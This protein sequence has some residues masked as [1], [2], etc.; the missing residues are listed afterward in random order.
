MSYLKDSRELVRRLGSGEEQHR[1][2]GQIA[3]GHCENISCDLIE[4]VRRILQSRDCPTHRFR[5]KVSTLCAEW[6]SA[7]LHGRDD[8]R[9]NA[10]H[11]VRAA[12]SQQDPARRSKHEK[13]G[14]DS[15]VPSSTHERKHPSQHPRRLRVT[16]AASRRATFRSLSAADNS[17]WREHGH[18]D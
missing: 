1:H 13:D 9:P 12:G 2:A 16:I 8:V 14:V 4:L 11:Q 10:L 17:G 3:S 18:E 6:L 7:A 5:H 15:R